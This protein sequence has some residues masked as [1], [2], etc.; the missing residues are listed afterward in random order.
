[1]D[2]KVA[3]IF[4]GQGAQYVEMGKGF[5]ETYS[6]VRETFEEA[7]DLLGFNLSKL[8]F[9]GPADELILTKNSQ[10]AIYVMSVALWR[11]VKQELP[12]IEPSVMAGLSLGEYSALTA[13]G[14]LAFKDGVRLV[15]ARGEYMYEAGVKF[16]GTMA[17]ALGMK[18]EEVYAIVDPVEGVWVA[19]LNCPGQVVVSGT[20]EGIEKASDLL[21][22]KGAKRV[23]PLDV[24]GAFHSGLM[25]GAKER[26]Q[27]KIDEID[28][29]ES[30]IDLV[31]NLPGDFVSENEIRKNMIGQVV[32]PVYWEKG[33]RKMEECGIQLFIEIG[34]GKTLSGINRK[35]GVDGKT[36]SIEKIEDLEALSQGA[37][38]DVT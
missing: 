33:V 4:P 11:V 9:E 25:G 26:L 19:N 31:M 30:S 12:Q 17:V 23:L 2:K 6:I 28:L 18:P 35:I 37:V 24:S 29:S 32:A 13:S 7:N 16:P 27:E 15:R 34:P 22:E 21:K 5:Y 1:M 36:I 14:R 8:M 10:I 3:F 38:N 20:V